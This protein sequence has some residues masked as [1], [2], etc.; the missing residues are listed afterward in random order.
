LEG[1][2]V[3]VYSR[4]AGDGGAYMVASATPS[5]LHALQAQGLEAT[6][7]QSTLQ[8]PPLYL[9]TWRAPGQLAE[10]ARRA[11][12]LH[13]DGAQALVRLPAAEA[14]ALARAGLELARLSPGPIELHP[15]R[16]AAMPGTIQPDPLVTQMIAQVRPA[17]LYLY[18]QWLTGGALALVGG[19]PYTITTRYTYSGASI[20]KATQLAH[21]HLSDLGLVVQYHPWAS[22]LYP[23][24]IATQ[25]GTTRPDDILI[26]SAHLDDMPGG[27]RA[28]GADDNASGSSAVLVAADILSQYSSECTLQYALWTGEEQGM[29]GSDAW[30]EWAGSQGLN[31]LGVLNLDMIAYD[32]DATP[33]VDLHARSWLPGS[34]VRS[35]AL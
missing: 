24:V 27:L 22:D 17:T 16:H 3:P 4:L 30:A 33:V 29:R 1:S 31:I 14:D 10:L 32:S 5:Q 9:V 8:G 26:L 15:K 13:S 35:R 2:G 25:P 7:L 21:E 18:E 6:V 19:Q 28:P 12:I 20:Q 34:M 11:R 23:N